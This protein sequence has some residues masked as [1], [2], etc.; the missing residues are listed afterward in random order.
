MKILQLSKLLLVVSLLLQLASIVQEY[1]AT[2][3][4][5]K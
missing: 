3:K 4:G 2:S 1:R 5:S